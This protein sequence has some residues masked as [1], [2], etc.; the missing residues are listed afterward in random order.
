MRV[1]YK[2]RMQAGSN[3]LS[4]RSLDF[5]LCFDLSVN[6]R[7]NGSVLR[8]KLGGL[9]RKLGGDLCADIARIPRLGRVLYDVRH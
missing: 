7:I 1:G 4:S 2:R 9:G 6:D 5:W 3:P 8:T